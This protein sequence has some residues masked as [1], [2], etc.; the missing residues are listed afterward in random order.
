MLPPHSDGGAPILNL[1]LLP[2]A[3]TIGLGVILTAIVVGWF[4]K[5]AK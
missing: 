4:I 5:L 2:P 1:L 3:V